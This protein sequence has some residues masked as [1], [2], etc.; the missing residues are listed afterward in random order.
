MLYFLSL[1]INEKK[2][3]VCISDKEVT[4]NRGNM[5]TCVRGKMWVGMWFSSSSENSLN[6]LCSCVSSEGGK[7]W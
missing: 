3:I 5:A 1:I 4:L 2:N 7:H 6:S